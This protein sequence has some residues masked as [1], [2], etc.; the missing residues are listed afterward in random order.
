[1]LPNSYKTEAKT[2]PTHERGTAQSLGLLLGAFL[3]LQTELDYGQR[4]LF[5]TEEEYT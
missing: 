4:H 5:W 3:S 1:M 2:T